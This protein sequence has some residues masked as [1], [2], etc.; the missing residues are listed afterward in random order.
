MAKN[1]RDLQKITQLMSDA[2]CNTYFA[3]YSFDTFFILIFDRYFMTDFP[4]CNLPSTLEFPSI[5]KLNLLGKWWI[6]ANE[7]W[8]NKLPSL[9]SSEMF[10]F[11][12]PLQAF[13]LA[14]LRWYGKSEVCSVLLKN[15][16]LEIIFKNGWKINVSGEP[17]QGESW[18]LRGNDNESVWSV[19]C[20]GGEYFIT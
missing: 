4:N 18:I 10:D 6:H 13:K 5:L 14:A 8:N 20:E 16:V 1:E 9:Q 11:E 17:V 2:L 7:E 3:G 12:E 19:T 15:E